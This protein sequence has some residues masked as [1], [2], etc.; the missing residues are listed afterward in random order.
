MKFLT[1]LKISRR[2]A[3]AFGICI[4]LLC[5]VSIL[6]ISALR[7]INQSL[8]LIVNDRYAKVALVGD[9]KE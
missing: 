5:L 6:S 1:D 8:K 7:T 3:L 4:A 2:L 9:L